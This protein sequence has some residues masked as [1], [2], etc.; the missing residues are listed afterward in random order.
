MLN[1]IFALLIV[2][3]ENTKHMKNSGI[4]NFYLYIDAPFIYTKPKAG[5]ED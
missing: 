1:C 2:Y 4:E 3:I 5:N